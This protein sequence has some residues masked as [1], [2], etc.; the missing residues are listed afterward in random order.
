MINSISLNLVH[1]SLSE[2]YS[3]L[4]IG[5][6]ISIYPNKHNNPLS[7]YK[8]NVVKISGKD[9]SYTPKCVRLTN[10]TS[11]NLML[12]FSQ[13]LNMNQ[14]EP[15]KSKQQPQQQQNNQNDDQKQPQNN[16]D[17]VMSSSFIWH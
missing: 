14:D 2:Y 3:S 6:E 1:K 7:S 17:K 5:D 10:Q 4:R 12:G 11:D 9:T 16:N 15:S 13:P 8:L